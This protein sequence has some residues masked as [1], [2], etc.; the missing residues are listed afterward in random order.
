MVTGIPFSNEWG[1]NQRHL[2]KWA[3]PDGATETLLQLSPAQNTVAV[4]GHGS[5][6]C[7]IVTDLE[8]T[9]HRLHKYL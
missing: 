6:D 3:D 2:A 1:K 5:K 4:N 8:W 9:S 7:S